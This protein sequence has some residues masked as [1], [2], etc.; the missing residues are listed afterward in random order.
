MPLRTLMTI[1]GKRAR[2]LK[3]VD[4][5]VHPE[6]KMLRMAELVREQQRRLA[7]E[8]E[9]HRAA[10]K[11]SVAGSNQGEGNDGMDKEGACEG[12]PGQVGD[13]DK[14]KPESAPSGEAVGPGGEADEDACATLDEEISHMVEE[15]EAMQ[16]QKHLL[17]V[18]LKELL[19]EEERSKAA[20]EVVEEEKKKQ[21]AA[22]FNEEGYL[23]SPLSPPPPRSARDPSHTH[24]RTDSTSPTDP[25]LPWL[26]PG[27][28]ASDTCAWLLQAVRCKRFHQP[29]AQNASTSRWPFL[30]L[31]EQP[32]AAAAAA[33]ATATA[34]AAAADAA[35]A[36]ILGSMFLVSR[37][38][39][40]HVSRRLQTTLSSCSLDFRPLAMGGVCQKYARLLLS[41]NG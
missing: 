9:A 19:K 20:A 38:R 5:T 15:L 7:A 29:N 12:A 31:A 11:A 40:R 34:A 17:F 13:E 35:A 32:L 10:K 8:E 26:Q 39:V 21:Q 30:A 33:A 4:G 27:S 2:T 3:S 41:Q 24:T 14:A 25:P 6:A 37:R 22:R 36:M 1:Q 28:R 23:P 18:R 16:K